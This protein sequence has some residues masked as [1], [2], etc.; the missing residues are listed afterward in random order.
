MP[1]KSFSQTAFGLLALFGALALAAY[2]DRLVFDLNQSARQ[3]FNFWPFLWLTPL[4][5]LLFFA[6]VLLLIRWLLARPSRNVL[7]AAAYLL[8]GLF[9]A[10][11][12]P[13]LFTF[14]LSG[15]GFP[16]DILRSSGLGSY[17]TVTA[18]LLALAGLFHLLRR[19]HV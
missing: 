7:L 8:L 4:I 6:A 13:L 16:T 17:W 15:L 12:V 14:N 19:P 9:V 1:S 2:L 18:T 5:S 11:Y 3:D 10:F